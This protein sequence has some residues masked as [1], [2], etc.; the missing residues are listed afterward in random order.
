M[1]K[2]L[3]KERLDVD[4]K[5]LGLIVF[6]VF[7]AVML[8]LIVNFS[9]NTLSGIRGYVA[10]EGYWA[11]AQKESVMHLS[12]F[13]I[14]EDEEDFLSFKSVLRINRGDK[15]GREEL[16]KDDFD[17]DIVFEGFEQ[18]LNHPDD[19]P[20]M[21]NLYRRFQDFPH[22]KDA[23]E[24]W[25]A[26][27]EKIEELVQFGDSVWSAINTSEISLQ[28]KEQWLERLNTLDH[29]L[30]ELEVRF[31]NAMGSVARLLNRIL[32]WATI[33]LGLLLILTGAWLTSRFYKSTKIW[34]DT[35]K[36]SETRFKEVLSNSKDVLYKMDLP[37]KKYVYVNPAIKKMLGYEKKEFLEGGAEFIISK[38]H[39]EDVDRMRSLV[40][41]YE[42]VSDGDFLPT[43]QFRMKDAE[44]NY[45]WVSN[46][47][48]LIRDKDNNPDAIVGSV[49]DITIQKVQE[50][51][52]KTSLKEKEIL[53]QEIHHRVKNN[54]SIVS[55]LLELQKANVKE[56]VQSLL[57]S[58]QTRIK[59]IA[60][61][62]EKLYQSTT[63]SDISLDIYISE[64]AEEIANA[65][66]SDQR[67]IELKLDVEPVTIHLD[68]AIPIGL[69]LNE[70]INN[71][72]KHG[73]NGHNEG[74]IK[75]SLA[76]EKHKMVMSVTN[77]GTPLPPDFDLKDRDSLG[78][79]LVNVLLKKI[80]GSLDIQTGEETSFVINFELD[81]AKAG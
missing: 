33:S 2:P 3:G 13:I 55:S 53:L 37:S 45:H 30:T 9:T 79:T 60:K 81:N 39:P 46:V 42:Q 59:S 70:L 43:V 58:S 57:S 74:Y 40:D 56:D 75:I 1:K 26:G 7:C 54:L 80:H 23:I 22:V 63:L 6:A 24:T 25:Q 10:G 27:D 48:T 34:M 52:L 17:Y 14:T 31:S 18:G 35:L 64:L 21:I 28:Q 32:R 77:N 16:Q 73:L 65:Y 19:I 20:H 66:Q 41:N 61:V 49:R 11:K 62:H 76:R 12:H 72:Y 8:I 69:I 78:M 29:E 4:R 38:L 67:N 51:E 15:V 44:G 50:K 68:E 36:E 5:I 71:A 47:R